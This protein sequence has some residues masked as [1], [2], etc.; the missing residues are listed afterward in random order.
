[1]SGNIFVH[2][3]LSNSSVIFL[4]QKQNYASFCFYQI[5]KENKRLKTGQALKRWLT[6]GCW[7]ECSLTEHIT[8]LEAQN[9]TIIEFLSSSE[10]WSSE[11]V[12]CS[13]GLRVKCI[14]V[15]RRKKEQHTT[16]Y[17]FK[18]AASLSPRNTIRHQTKDEVFLCSCS[19]ARG[20]SKHEAMQIFQ[21]QDIFYAS[22]VWTSSN[23]AVDFDIILT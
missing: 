18:V 23:I 13:V 19:Q 6:V 1:M 21:V 11:I 9:T 7:V 2:L 22:T 17:G 10:R 4:V 12:K 5:S 14:G 16:F 15:R 3:A 20:S 8:I